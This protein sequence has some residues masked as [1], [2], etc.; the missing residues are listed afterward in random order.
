MTKPRLTV[1]LVLLLAGLLA[2]FAA[3]A[4]AQQLGF[5]GTE[6]AAFG[7]AA[8]RA[9]SGSSWLAGGSFGG[10]L[11]RYALLY[12]EGSYSRLGG[13]TLDLGSQVQGTAT[14]RFGQGDITEAYGG[15]QFQYPIRN[16]RIA[17]FVGFG[18][19]VVRSSVSAQI[20]VSGTTDP[21]TGRPLGGVSV[22]Q[23]LRQTSVAY[24][25]PVGLRYYVGDRW[26]VKPEVASVIGS[27][28]TTFSR[29]S[30]G[31]FFQSGR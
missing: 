3:P 16:T 27:G 7:G 13:D 26:G 25:I 15:A 24:T 12:G 18:L 20:T 10:A 22:T 6:V 2:L 29:F 4:R 30:I 9:S 17:P 31:I 5:S 8:Y 1:N 11:S 28:F 14:A 19:G 23:N 21:F